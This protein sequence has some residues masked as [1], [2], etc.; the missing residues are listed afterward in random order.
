[1]V[2]LY[3]HT[4]SPRLDYILGFFTRELFDEPVSVTTDE[5]AFRNADAYRINYSGQAFTENEFFIQAKELLFET[6][7]EKQE[8]ACIEV[9][10]FKAFYQTSGDFPFDIFAATFY[11]LSRSEEYLPHELDE[12]GR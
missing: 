8:I 11:L 5:T 10:Y 6:G 4:L 7:I 2:I 9:N 1:M 12:H 3:T